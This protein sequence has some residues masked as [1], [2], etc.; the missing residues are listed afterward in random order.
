MSFQVKDLFQD[1]TI[2][3]AK[4][5]NETNLIQEENKMSKRFITLSLLIIMIS[6]CT[7]QVAAPT[8][9]AGTAQP[10]FSTVE[11]VPT[12]TATPLIV[13]GTEQPVP[14]TGVDCPGAPA[15]HVAIGQQVTVAVD[16]TDKLKLRETPEISPDT[17]VKGLDKF[18]QLK[19]LDG[20]VCA[21]STDPAVSYWFWKVEVQPNGEIGW[22]A[23]G[24]SLN[25][26]IEIAS[27]L[28][29]SELPAPTSDSNCPGAPATHV[30]IGQQVTVVVDD[31]DKLKLRETPEISPDTEVMVLDKLTHLKIL[32][33]PVC[34]SS[35]DP[36]VSYWFWK[37]QVLPSGEAGWVAEGDSS[38]YFIE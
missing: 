17:E 8:T 15:L 27:E 3:L 9:P 23:E 16:D 31:T 37:V 6:A 4:L 21:A 33:G 11:S 20:P 5:Q 1:S 19:I 36:K 2:I 26:F 28:P 34:V 22:V 18:T 10:V 12:V 13:G 32:E 7:R 38:N 24:D 25:Y 14:T 30:A 35:A 29:A